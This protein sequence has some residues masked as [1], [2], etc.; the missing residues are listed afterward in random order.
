MLRFVLQS[1]IAVTLASL[2]SSYV[3]VKGGRHS[4]TPKGDSAPIPGQGEV[5]PPILIQDQDNTQ[6]VVTSKSVIEDASKN[7]AAE[8]NHKSNTFSNNREEQVDINQSKRDSSTSHTENHHTNNGHEQKHIFKEVK[9]S[10]HHDEVAV[11]N[12]VTFTHGVGL[13]ENI[14]QNNRSEN[15]FQLSISDDNRKVSVDNLEGQNVEANHNE[16]FLHVSNKQDPSKYHIEQLSSFDG[17]RIDNDQNTARNHQ[18]KQV[19]A[20]LPI[21]LHKIFVSNFERKLDEDHQ[22]NQ[23]SSNSESNQN[24]KAV[25]H[26]DYIG[27]D[28]GIISGIRE[29]EYQN[30]ADSGLNTAHSKVN[31]DTNKSQHDIGNNE[32]HVHKQ[33]TNGNDVSHAHKQT[34]VDNTEI[35]LQE[36]NHSIEDSMDKGVYGHEHG[37]GYHH[38]SIP[39]YHD[40]HHHHPI[41]HDSHSFEQSSEEYDDYH[42]DPHHYSHHGHGSHGHGHH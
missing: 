14:G 6:N 19:N 41:H 29:T 7:I 10:S 33:N 40:S 30:K 22:Q 24:H 42:F 8:L 4:I 35:N 32:E 1:Y 2:A 23:E 11:R 28:S 18:S 34:N 3:P 13:K 16:E 15:E 38:D 36:Q 27:K 12:Q 26:N 31:E 39:Y 37:H 9:E 5:L 21:D 20:E 17:V 25:L